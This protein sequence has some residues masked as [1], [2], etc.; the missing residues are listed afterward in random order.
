VGNLIKISVDGTD[1]PIQ[2]P[3]PFSRTWYSHKIN[4]AALKYEIAI[5]IMTGKMC[6]IS[7]PYPGSRH[8]LTIFRN[9]LAHFLD[10][11][12]QVHADRGYK[13]DDRISTPL[14]QTLEEKMQS[15]VIR[16]RHETCNSR[17]KNFYSLST[18]FRHPLEKH[19]QV[20]RAV[21]VVCQLA[22]E[23]GEPLFHVS[24]HELLQIESYLTSQSLNYIFQVVRNNI[25]LIPGSG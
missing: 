23:R 15:K 6:W 8:D 4:K 24:Y 7:G 17:I 9:G 22:F 13:G 12:E 2:E 1:C 20:F 18:K 10:E 19:G 14:N 21:A 16:A 11:D 3:R 5:N 25:D